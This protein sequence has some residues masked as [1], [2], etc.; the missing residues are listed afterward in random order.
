MGNRFLTEQTVNSQ[1][2]KKKKK[3]KKEKDQSALTPP[4]KCKLPKIMSVKFHK[5]RL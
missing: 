4:K 2:L 1:T 5:N 3:K